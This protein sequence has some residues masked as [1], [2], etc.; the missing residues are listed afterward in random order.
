[1]TATAT[2]KHLI[3][4]RRPAL[5]GKA[6]QYG[7]GYVKMALVKVD[8][9]ILD[10]LGLEEPAMISER[11][12]GMIQV[13]ECRSVFMGKGAKSQGSQYRKELEEKLAQL[14]NQ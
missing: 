5:G 2:T 10:A 7:T 4:T 11:S 13:I 9:Q 14:N 8:C 12:R 6:R 3:M 1:M